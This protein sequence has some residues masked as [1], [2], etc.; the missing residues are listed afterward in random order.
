MQNDYNAKY[1]YKQNFI[2]SVHN[3]EDCHAPSFYLKGKKKADKL[4]NLKFLWMVLE[5]FPGPS[6]LSMN[7]NIISLKKN[8]S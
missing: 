5:D 8:L 3:Q 2:S 6:V 4:E 7:Q 1:F